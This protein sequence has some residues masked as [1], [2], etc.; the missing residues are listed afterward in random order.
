MRE[1]P[2]DVEGMAEVLGEWLSN[3][4]DVTPEDRL[5][6]R[7]ALAALGVPALLAEVGLARRILQFGNSFHT[8]ARFF[9]DGSAEQRYLLQLMDE[10][11]H[12]QAGERAGEW[13]GDGDAVM[14][15]RPPAPG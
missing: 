6:A 5:R 7:E 14:S 8:V 3:G 9:A 11:E 13:A 10:R 4:S 15:Q 12:E 1:E 2:L